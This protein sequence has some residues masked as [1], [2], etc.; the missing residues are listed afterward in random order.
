M[1]DDRKLCGSDLEFAARQRLDRGFAF[2]S[3]SISL[4]VAEPFSSAPT[5]RAF[6]MKA[7]L[8]AWR[9]LRQRWR[10]FTFGT[11]GMPTIRTGAALPAV[12]PRRTSAGSFN[13]FRD[14]ALT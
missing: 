9:G 6:S 14:V 8:Y 5:L 7:L 12:D 4:S 1:Q 13:P 10:G 3:R 11:K 2:A